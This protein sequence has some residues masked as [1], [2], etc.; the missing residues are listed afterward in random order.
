LTAPLVLERLVVAHVR[1]LTE[2]AL[3]PAPRLNVVCGDNGHGKTSL[4]EALYLAATS[5]SFRTASLRELVQHGQETASARAV[6]REE[7][8]GVPLSRE[9]SVG[10]RG[11]RRTVR[12]DGEE[13]PTLAY[14]ATRSPVVVFDSKQLALSTGPASERRTL[15]DRVV[16]FVDPGMAGHRARYRR[17]LR[18]RQ[19]VLADRGAARSAELDA[20]EQLLAEHGA[21]LTRAR[22]HASGLLGDA[23]EA[24]FARIAAPGLRVRIGYEAA[25]SD[26]PAEARERLAAGRG[27]DARRRRAAFGP[28]G[29]DLA[30]E[31]DGHPARAVASQ[32]QHRA[33]TLALKSAELACIAAARG[34]QP[35]LLL[36]DV[37]SELDAER[38]AA[39]LDF[40][41]T[42]SSQLFL[43]TTR[44]ALI[45]RDLGPERRDFVM[46]DGSLREASGTR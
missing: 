18:E 35:I 38:T 36:D 41:A 22:R 45:D 23:M 27:D 44:P 42:T 33:L 24:A 19:R 25:G 29:D 1:N 26:D 16:L 43:T 39:L 10:V 17:A 37:S 40:L 13:P 11:G 30:L 32:G 2:L 28:H 31:L 7:S 8:A 46:K 9:Q 12:L 14:F 15:L 4:L 20:Y 6:F 34:L 21:A 3:E 5:R